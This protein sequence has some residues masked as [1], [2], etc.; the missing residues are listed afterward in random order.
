MQE[1]EEEEEQEPQAMQTTRAADDLR[2]CRQLERQTT[3]GDSQIRP[4]EMQ[5]TSGDAWE[6]EVR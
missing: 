1:V 2:R 3:S 4:Q 6:A 5:T